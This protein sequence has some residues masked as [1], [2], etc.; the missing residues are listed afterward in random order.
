MNEKK[1]CNA[2]SINQPN[3]T[4]LVDRV[5]FPIICHKTVSRLQLD[6]A[7]YDVAIHPEEKVINKL[8]NLQC[9]FSSTVV[10]D[11]NQRFLNDRDKKK[12][13]KRKREKIRKIVAN[14][15]MP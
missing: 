5:K 2:T 7:I 9:Q 10:Q 4:K 1:K 11:S 6:E 13:K 8:R 3:V 15:T 14:F 12:E